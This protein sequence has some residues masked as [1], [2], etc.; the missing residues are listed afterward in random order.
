MLLIQL[1]TIAHFVIHIGG[2]KGYIYGNPLKT[3]IS[4]LQ[5][6]YEKFENVKSA[7]CLSWKKGP[8]YYK[9]SFYSKYIHT[10]NELV[11]KNTH[12]QKIKPLCF[13]G[14]ASPA[15]WVSLITRK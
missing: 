15:S 12:V 6:I 7:Y 5:K 2:N 9:I 11:I 8:R 10:F 13:Y 14:M 4:K 1:L 3:A